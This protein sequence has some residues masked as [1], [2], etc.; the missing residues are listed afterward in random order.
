VFIFHGLLKYRR[1][2]KLASGNLSLPVGCAMFEGAVRTGREADAEGVA[3]IYG[4]MVCDTAISFELEPPTPQEWHCASRLLGFRP[5]GIYKE[6]GF[7]RG[8]WRDV[9]WWRGLSDATNAP[10]EPVAFSALT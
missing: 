4:P 8:Q 3:A 10:A 7:K 9:G 6:V 1:G 5:V 2:V